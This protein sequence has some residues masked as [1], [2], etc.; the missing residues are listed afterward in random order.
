MHR[1]VVMLG[2]VGICACEGGG[3]SDGDAE[4]DRVDV[5][6]DAADGPD[7]EIA[8]DAGEDGDESVEIEHDVPVEAEDAVDVDASDAHLCRAGEGFCRVDYDVGCPPTI[9]ADGS[10]CGESMYCDYCDSSYPPYWTTASCY[11]GRWEVRRTVC[12]PAP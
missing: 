5:V 12:D 3:G 9:P 2:A 7:G 6:E 11:G 1:V 8:N 10:T 4:E